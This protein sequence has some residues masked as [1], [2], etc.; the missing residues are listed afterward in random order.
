[1]NRHIVRESVRDERMQGENP[2]SNH[3]GC[4]WW[5][6]FPGSQVSVNNDVTS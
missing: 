2:L 1:M 4:Q 3:D 5:S 6:P